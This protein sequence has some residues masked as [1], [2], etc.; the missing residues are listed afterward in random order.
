MLFWYLFPS[1]LRNS[2]NKHQNNPLV[3]TETI[4]PSSTYIILYV[5]WR[6]KSQGYTS[7]TILRTRM[8]RFKTEAMYFAPGCPVRILICLLRDNNYVTISY[9]G[10]GRYI[11]TE[12]R[13]ISFPIFHKK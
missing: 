4:R 5:H 9:H 7:E 6:L 13:L 1:L 2:G 12:S 10:R 3:R 8:T 11:G